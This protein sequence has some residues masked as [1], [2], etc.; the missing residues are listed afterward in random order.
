MQ[1]QMCVQIDTSLNIRFNTVNW[2]FVVFNYLS[3]RN[4]GRLA[5][6]IVDKYKFSRT[7]IYNV[8]L[9]LMECHD[10]NATL[11]KRHV[12]ARNLGPGVPE[13]MT[14]VRSKDSDQLMHLHSPSISSLR[15]L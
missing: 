2:H 5:H 14:H 11:Y 1:A 8:A 15:C 7:W 3:L 13:K 9:T 12:P 6:P 10:V 4:Q